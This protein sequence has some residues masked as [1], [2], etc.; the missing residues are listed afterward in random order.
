M[1]EP[2]TCAATHAL[3]HHPSHTHMH[4]HT[5]T[6]HLFAASCAE[7]VA[8]AR[9]AARGRR[10]RRGSN[11]DTC[12]DH[13]TMD[14]AG[15]PGRGCQPKPALLLRSGTRVRSWLGFNR[16]RALNFNVGC[17]H[18]HVLSMFVCDAVYAYAYVCT[19]CMLKRTYHDFVFFLTHARR[20][21]AIHTYTSTAHSFA[22]LT[23]HGNRTAPGATS[24]HGIG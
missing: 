22:P 3:A 11:V 1:C 21:R 4:T 14:T 6:P 23:R 12:V 2:H 19:R 7:H 15:E 10:R 8:W 13:H 5:Y 18:A 20:W 24:L 9:C 17:R 16:M